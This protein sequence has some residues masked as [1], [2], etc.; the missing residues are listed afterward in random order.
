MEEHLGP[1]VPI[2]DADDV[3]GG[4]IVSVNGDGEETSYGARRKTYSGAGAVEG[5]MNPGPLSLP[6]PSSTQSPNI[7]SLLHQPLYNVHPSGS[8][9]LGAGKPATIITAGSSRQS[10]T[11]YISTS[12]VKTGPPKLPPKFNKLINEYVGACFEDN[13][14]I[15]KLSFFLN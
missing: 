1:V 3:G 14:N 9:P 8:L 5:V 6:I 15:G 4:G 11:Q 7:S 12:G 2:D 10:Q 13:C